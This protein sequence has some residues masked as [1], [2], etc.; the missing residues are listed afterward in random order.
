[1]NTPNTAMIEKAAALANQATTNLNFVRVAEVGIQA[2][3]SVQIFE[4]ILSS[5]IYSDYEEGD[6]NGEVPA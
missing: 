1:M 3:L 6:T 5:L 2:K 4:T